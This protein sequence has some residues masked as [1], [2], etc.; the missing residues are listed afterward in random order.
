MLQ[1]HLPLRVDGRDAE[2]VAYTATAA[3]IRMLNGVTFEVA[4]DELVYGAAGK[5]EFADESERDPWANA[6]ADWE[7]VT[8]D[9]K[10]DYRIASGEFEWV[11][12]GSFPDWLTEEERIRYPERTRTKTERIEFLAKRRGLANSS[13]WLRYR[14]YRRR[15]RR[16]A[17]GKPRVG[18]HVSHPSVH[19]RYIEEVR[20]YGKLLLDSGESVATAQV[21]HEDVERRIR[22]I[23]RDEKV[24]IGIP[25]QSVRYEV[26]K[27]TLAAAGTLSS[28]IARQE[29][30]SHSSKRQFRRIAPTRPGQ[31]VLADTTRLDVRALS[32]FS[33]KAHALELTW[34]LDLYSRV[35]LAIQVSPV[36]TG[37]T[38]ITQLFFDL[39]RPRR[40]PWAF[41][42]GVTLPN[43]GLPDY[44]LINARTGEFAAEGDDEA[45]LVPSVRPETLVTD[46]GKIYISEQMHQICGTLHISILYGRV[47]KADDKAQ[48]EASFRTLRVSLSVRL[49]GSTGGE[50]SK[51]GR[52]A[53]INAVWTMEELNNIVRTWAAN[54]YH[55][56]VH[57]GLHRHGLPGVACTPMEKLH[58]GIRRSGVRL[59]NHSAVD[60]ID[61]LPISW[62]SVQRY[63]VNIDNLVYDG[64]VLKEF[65]RHKSRYLSKGGRWPIAVNTMDRQYVYFQHPATGRWHALRWIGAES[66][67]G[68]FSQSMMEHSIKQQYGSNGMRYVHRGNQH[69][70]GEA[71]AAWLDEMAAAAN[72]TRREDAILLRATGWKLPLRTV[73]TVIDTFRSR[74]TFKT[75]PNTPKHRAEQVVTRSRK[76]GPN[77]APLRETAVEASAPRKNITADAVKADSYWEDSY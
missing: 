74:I 77:R 28:A 56:T 24:T 51:R 37:G 69:V 59:S 22:G 61:L 33:G 36:T 43:A 54:F 14:A 31:Y 49:L 25:K 13:I 32:V 17:I 15:D 58:E 45:D 76:H 47:Q 29:G 4:I 66:Y 8:D 7:T 48:I 65:I 67:G 72:V 12:S 44:L 11:S 27:E 3:T 19:P 5:Y 26:V 39:L 63:G 21:F 9:W 23:E 38:D 68:P 71:I 40:E 52:N 6:Q 70:V 1:R 20:N 62:V 46:N 30:I 41:H 10:D 50:P 60:A 55:H 16:G 73:E 75:S 42:N 57:D 2:V 35:I 18:R 34:L 64:D 53:D